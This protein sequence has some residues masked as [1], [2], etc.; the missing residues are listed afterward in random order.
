MP[1]QYRG[2]NKVIGF[3]KAINRR[4][5]APEPGGGTSIGNAGSM[6]IGGS[7]GIGTARVGGGKPAP[8]P[9][10]N[11]KRKQPF[12]SAKQKGLAVA[13]RARSA[14]AA[15]VPGGGGNNSPGGNVYG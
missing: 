7:N 1:M 6:R 8:V 3:P 15:P 2:G 14:R 12:N 4:P 11:M 5:S 13:L 9:G 10:T